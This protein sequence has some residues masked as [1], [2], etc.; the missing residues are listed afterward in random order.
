MANR[1]NIPLI[2]EY[3][4]ADT[5][6]YGADSKRR[7]PFSLND[8]LRSIFALIH[9][10][11]VVESVRREHRVDMHAADFCIRPCNNL[12]ISMHA[13]YIEIY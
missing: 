12:R 5:S 3:R 9:K 7:G 6:Y 2:E 11:G 10:F 1:A 4:R 8:A 13:Q